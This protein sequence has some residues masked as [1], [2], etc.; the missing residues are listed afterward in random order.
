MAI[1]THNFT[2]QQG[3]DAVISMVYK[4]DSAPV[5]LSAALLRMDVGPVGGERLYTFNSEDVVVEGDTDDEAIL[6]ADGTI[7]IRIPRGVT[8]QGGALANSVGSVLEYD[9]FLRRGG[10][11]SKILKGQIVVE[12]SKTLWN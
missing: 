8:L 11:Q 4:V 12:A 7:N 5:D 9:V 2:W 10:K 1:P 3:E 6:G